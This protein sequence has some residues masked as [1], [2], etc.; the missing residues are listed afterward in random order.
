MH[1]RWAIIFCYRYIHIIYVSELIPTSTETGRAS[2]GD[3]YHTD[4]H[5]SKYILFMK[6]VYVRAHVEKR[7]VPVLWHISMMFHFRYWHV[8][9]RYWSTRS[10]GTGL[11]SVWALTDTRD[12]FKN[13]KE[14]VSGG[15]R[16]IQNV[17]AVYI[18]L[19]L[20]RSTWVCF[21]TVVR[22]TLESESRSTKRSTSK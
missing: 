10:T 22:F 5:N 19:G 7:P 4:V 13:K 12:G 9:F 21:D 11:F 15:V 18:C 2:T 14:W 17:R 20:L 8:Q 1:G 6:Y 3:E 16:H